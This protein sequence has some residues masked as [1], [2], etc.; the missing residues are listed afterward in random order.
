MWEK[1]SKTRELSTREDIL[2]LSCKGQVEDTVRKTMGEERSIS[3]NDLLVRCVQEIRCE[4]RTKGAKGLIEELWQISSENRGK[5]NCGGP[6]YILEVL[7]FV[8]QVTMSY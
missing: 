2:R 6:E 3:K 5:S 1:Y 8:S 7:D 4:V